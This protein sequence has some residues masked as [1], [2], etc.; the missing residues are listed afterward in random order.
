VAPFSS[1]WHILIGTVIELHTVDEGFPPRPSD[2]SDMIPLVSVF[3]CD[4]DML[5]FVRYF[6][7]EL[8]IFNVADWDAASC[9][10]F[11]RFKLS[12]E[13]TQRFKAKIGRPRRAQK[14]CAK[15]MPLRSSHRPA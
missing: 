15:I 6:L 10:A 14:V 12:D 11:D 1:P 7:N 13:L 8:G 5:P 3:S 2:L 9:N 4:R